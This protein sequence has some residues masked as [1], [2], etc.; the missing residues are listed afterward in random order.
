MLNKPL[1]YFR[2]AKLLAFHPKPFF[3]YRKKWR[4]ARNYAFFVA[5]MK[6][7]HIFDI[8]YR[9]IT[10]RIVYHT[11]FWVVLFLVLIF[12]GDHGSNGW[13]KIFA[14]EFIGLLFYALLV[15]F[16]LFYLIP[17]FLAKRA[18]LY[19]LLVII[20]CA[21]ISPIKVMV[22][23]L[24]YTGSPATQ[25]D[26]IHSQGT[27][28]LGNIVLVLFSTMLKVFTDWWRYQQEKQV[29][30]TQTIQSELRF[31][32]TQINPHFLF[33]TLNNLYA[34]TLKK[35]DSAPEIVLKLSEIMRYMLYECNEKRV[36]LVRE[37]QYIRNYLDLERLRQ[38]KGVEINF[39]T[40]GNIANQLIAPLIFIPF[41]ENAFKHGLTNNIA[42]GF[43]RMQLNVLDEDLEFIIENSKPEGLP[44]QVHPRSGGIG[45]TNLRQRLQM[46]YPENYTLQI[47][48]RPDKYAVQL[49]LKLT[50]NA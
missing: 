21:I 50:N 6:M 31:L 28:F 25:L 9:F 29:L 16:N 34:L 30:L 10:T 8:L 19:L 17:N 23:Y 36:P 44:R 2:G 20:S 45:L 5:A 22:F 11:C 27:V 1:H 46:I 18:F 24:R 39:E 14:D 37:I 26:L 43:V 12:Y 38:P 48:D 41:L 13:S 3:V 32:K 15:Y 49:L 42:G 7:Q 47:D 4:K 35:S 33:N 40:N